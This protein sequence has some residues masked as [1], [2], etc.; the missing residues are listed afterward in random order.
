MEKNKKKGLGK[1]LGTLLSSDFNKELVIND[2]ERIKKILVNKIVPKKDQPR[3]HFDEEKL[4]ELATS[5]KRH[6][7]LMPLVVSP[8]KDDIYQIIAG[9]R[10]WRAAM[11]AG[12]DKVPVVV[13]SLKELEKLEIAL[14]ENIQRVDLNSLEQATSLA[15][16]HVQFSMSY[17]EIAK[18]LGKAASTVNNTIRLLNLPDIAKEA[19]SKNKIS[20]GHA[21]AILALKNFPEQQRHL[22]Q[23]ILSAG[24]SVRQAER[25][26]V[27][28]KEGIRDHKIAK[29][30]VLTETTETKKL[31]KKLSTTV[32]LRRMAKGGRLE[33]TF[34]NDKELERIISRIN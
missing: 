18:R 16:L 29:T 19:L 20:E 17:D 25:Y 12:L 22:L 30:R 26:V 10:R 11:M 7:I 13:R 2:D 9:E 23:S 15:K 1:G 21:R 34:K 14:V 32:S 3:N 33:I 5:I 31:A 4:N 27:S 28:C 6:G 24:W 8:L